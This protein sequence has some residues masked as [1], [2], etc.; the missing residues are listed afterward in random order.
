MSNRSKNFYI[1]SWKKYLLLFSIF[2][3]S[4]YCL[5]EVKQF[6]DADS[7]YFYNPFIISLVFAI[8]VGYHL[9]NLK[10]YLDG[11]TLVAEGLIDRSISIDKLKY[12]LVRNKSIDLI[13]SFSLFSLKLRSEI[14]ELRELTA[15]ID[16]VLIYHP[17][18][19]LKGPLEYREK[20]FPKTFAAR[21]T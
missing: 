8:P 17:E 2:L 4:V 5:Y 3:G 11:K 15:L 16:E 9:Y 7:L 12:I 18:V 20:W 10:Y 14:Q 13:N 19:K 6:H 21:K 1:V